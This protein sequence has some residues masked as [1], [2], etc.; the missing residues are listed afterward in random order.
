[1]DTAARVLIRNMRAVV[2]VVDGQ[3]AH[4]VLRCQYDL[5]GAKRRTYGVRQVAAPEVRCPE[6][7]HDI[8]ENFMAG[9]IARESL[10][11]V[12]TPQKMCRLD[13]VGFRLHVDERELR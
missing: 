6:T 8:P 13:E 2:V 10:A 9:R 4:V 11:G 1:R 5:C 12:D 7:P 3:D